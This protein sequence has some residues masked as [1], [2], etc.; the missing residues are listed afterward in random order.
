MPL[1]KE[2]KPVLY[3][4]WKNTSKSSNKYWVYVKSNTKKGY[5]KIG[6]GLKGMQDFSQHKDQKR[7]KS[8]LARAKGIKN[9]EG[10]LTYK[11]KNTANYWAV[12]LWADPSPSWG[13]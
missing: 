3:K 4:P 11:D 13:K 12:K 6:F 2:G 7:R 8:Y 9:K 5:K 10:K 1:T